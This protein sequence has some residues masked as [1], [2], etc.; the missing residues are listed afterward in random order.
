MIQQVFFANFRALRG[1]EV[2]LG[3]LTVIV[4]PNASGKTTMLKGLQY[5]LEAVRETNP[6]DYFEHNRNPLLL[7]SRSSIGRTRVGIE[8]QNGTVS[9]EFSVPKGITLD[10]LYQQAGTTPDWKLTIMSRRHGHDEWTNIQEDAEFLAELP[11]VRLLKLEPALLASASSPTYST[12]I[13][14]RGGGL[15]SALWLLHGKEY[16]TFKELERQ[17]CAVIPSVKRIRFD[18]VPDPG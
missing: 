1:V 17:L 3:P 12:E 6:Y 18:R 13:D 7:A 9:F 14:E 5:L 15:A 8:T 11:D 4:G 10:T 2:A 16:D